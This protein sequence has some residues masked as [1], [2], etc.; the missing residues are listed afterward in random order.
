M[1]FCQ[2]ELVIFE[3]LRMEKSKLWVMIKAYA[4]KSEN[5][6]EGHPVLSKQD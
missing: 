5:R 3:L 4:K 2:I 6:S 1:N